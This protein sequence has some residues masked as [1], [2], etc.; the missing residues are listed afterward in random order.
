M[1]KVGDE[2]R[3]LENKYFASKANGVYYEKGDI[4]LITGI[5]DGAQVNR[6]RLGS[7]G[8]GNW[9][10]VSEI[11]KVVRPLPEEEEEETE[12]TEEDLYEG[13]QLI[14][15]KNDSGRSLWEIGEIYEITKTNTGELIIPEAGFRGVRDASD[16]LY[17][18][19]NDDGEV[20]FKVLPG[21]KDKKSKE[22]AASVAKNIQAKIDELTTEAEKLFAKR[23]R[24]NDQAINLNAKARRLEELLE[25]IKEFE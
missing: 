9:I 14:C 8:K 5:G 4:D 21:Q 18:L 12:Y 11:E 16:I 25:A 20:R 2:V 13:M 19:N 23:D 6:V 10:Y 17:Y 7:Y 3:V 22:E 24:V 15:I 1:F